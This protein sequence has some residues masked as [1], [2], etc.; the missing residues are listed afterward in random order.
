MNEDDLIRERATGQQAERLLADLKPYFK[1]LEQRLTEG[2]KSCPAHDEKTQRELKLSLK[3]L[4]TLEADIA[5]VAT[6]GRLAQEKLNGLER[7]KL[8]R[9]RA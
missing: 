3:L 2:W 8:W 5:S 9:R 6:T 7:L 1:K 4:Q